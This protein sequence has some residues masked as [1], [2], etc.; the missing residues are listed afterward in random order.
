MTFDKM[1]ALAAGRANGA[2][3]EVIFNYNQGVYT[4][5]P[6][7]TAGL[8][9]LLEHEFDGRTIGGLSWSSRVLRHYRGKADEEGTL[10]ADVL[11]HV[12]LKTSAYSYSK[13]VLI[14]AKRK[15]AE[16]LTTAEHVGLVSQ[17]KRMLRITPAAFVF[18]Y[19]KQGI[20]CGSATLVAGT[21]DKN[22]GRLCKWSSR[23]FFTEL[24][25]CPIGDPRVTIALAAVSPTAEP[26]PVL[27]AIELEGK[28][29]LDVDDEP[30]PER[31][32]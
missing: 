8:I 23:R 16:K 9:T 28:G 10:G 21:T 3:R 7:I 30:L 13:G 14:Q 18:H 5:E 12:T 29:D 19:T 15:R 1:V 4:D 17:C 31:A 2:V 22:L 32:G 11:L 24:F 27:H 25:R 20:F 26:P 6:E